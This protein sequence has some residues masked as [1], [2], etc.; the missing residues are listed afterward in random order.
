V[1]LLIGIWKKGRKEGRKEVCIYVRSVTIDISSRF[2]R[3]AFS[4]I[5]DMSCVYI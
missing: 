5:N 4:E 1:A 2:V 3:L